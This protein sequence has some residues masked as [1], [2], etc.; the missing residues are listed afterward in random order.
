MRPP[1]YRSRAPRMYAKLSNFPLGV[2]TVFLKRRVSG[3]TVILSTSYGGFRSLLDDVESGT[4][5]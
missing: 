5:G 1:S 3:Q 4:N 2:A